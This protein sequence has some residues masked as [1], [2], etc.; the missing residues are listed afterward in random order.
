MNTL[1]LAGDSALAK[2]EERPLLTGREREVLAW[3]A[4]GKSAAEIG[5]ILN[6]AKRTVDEHTQ[7]AMRK[8]DA[9]SRTQAVAIAI[10]HRLF[11]I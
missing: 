6:V 5:E 11:E 7:M 3:S 2:F 4:E 10:R 8:L 9:T 1:S